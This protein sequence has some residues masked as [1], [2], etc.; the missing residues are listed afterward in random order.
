[1]VLLLADGEQWLLCKRPSLT[2]FF[3]ELNFDAFVGTVLVGGAHFCFQM[4]P[5]VF[6]VF[7]EYFV[8]IGC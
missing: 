3:S 4:F 2:V 6:F 5:N 8:S 1:M 7:R